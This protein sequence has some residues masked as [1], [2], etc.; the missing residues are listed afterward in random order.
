M[1][2]LYLNTGGLETIFETLQDSLQGTLKLDN[3]QYSLLVKSKSASGT[4]SGVSFTK[5]LTYLDFDM[6]FNDDVVLSMESSDNSPVVFAYCT[7]GNVTHSFGING[8]KKNLK[9]KHSG[10]LRNTSNINSVLFFKA[11][12]RV[13]FSIISSNVA[14]LQNVEDSNLFSDLKEMFAKSSDNYRYVGPLNLKIAEKL[15]EFK[16]VPQK[17]IVGNLLKKRILENILETEIILHSYGYIR[18]IQP[19]IALANK[20]IDDLKRISNLNI[21]EVLYGVGQAGRHLPRLLKGKY[22]LAF[23]FN[24]L[25]RV[26]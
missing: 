11:F 25:K 12:E 8:E 14:S 20:Q 18:A 1:K 26:S 3:D 19:I 15:E 7:Q 24:T 17:G 4:I 21:S 2:K 16:N 10:I 23:S 13:K 6:E 9:E 5:Q 22:H